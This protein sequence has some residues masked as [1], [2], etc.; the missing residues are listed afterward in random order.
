MAEDDSNRP[1][2]GRNETNTDRDELERIFS[3]YHRKVFAA[4][5]R[6]TGNASDAEDVLQ[7]VFLRLL[8]RK[9]G[10][11][12]SDQPGAY[13]YRAA[14]NAAVDLLRARRRAGAVPLDEEVRPLAEGDHR[15]P[16]R[17]HAGREM[18]RQ[19]RSAVLELSPEGAEV[20]TL[21]Y[22]EGLRNQEIATLLGKSQTSVG[23][24]LFRAR[25]KVRSELEPLLGG[26]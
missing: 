19:L 5:Y 15:A 18:R 20:F 8:N 9:S 11:K 3:E 26:V 4:A 12:L 17:L 14:V 2:R 1:D 16:D 21:K 22:F 10:R 6:V 25:N 24:M 7:T 23:V 13:L